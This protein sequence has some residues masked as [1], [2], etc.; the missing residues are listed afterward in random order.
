MRMFVL[1]ALIAPLLA[2]CAG[3]PLVMRSIQH[4]VVMPE[5]ILFN[6]PTVTDLPESRTLTDVQVARLI[7]Q[8]Y[9]NNATCKN[10]MVAL[11]QFLEAAQ[12]T[13]TTQEGQ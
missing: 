6:C 12:R 4:T 8:L 2:A 9:Q 1:A 3:D 13:T 7:V 11:R 5:E 10:S